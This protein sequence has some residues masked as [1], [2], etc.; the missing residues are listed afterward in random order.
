MLGCHVRQDCPRLFPLG[1]PLVRVDHHGVQHLARGIHHGTLHT[2]AVSRVQAQRGALSRGRGQQQI[3]QVPG[4]HLHRTFIGAFLEPH[5]HVHRGAHGEL[6][7]PR[8]AH[9]LGAEFVRG[10]P[11]RFQLCQL[12]NQML[13]VGIICILI[14]AITSGEVHAQHA[15][16]LPAQ[17][18]QDAVAGQLV[19]WLGKLEV[20]AVLGSGILLP[21]DHLGDGTAALEVFLTNPA[22]HV[23]I[24]GN[25]LHHDVPRTREHRG[26]IGKALGDVLGRQLRG[27]L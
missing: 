14:G 25:I 22:H 15:F 21:G 23:C 7:P 27:I 10:I 26:S 13:E 1:L 2:V 8:E 5:S 6:G 24:G 16:G 11:L 9:A 18:R 17:Q 12:G 4:K 3:P 19:E 20:I